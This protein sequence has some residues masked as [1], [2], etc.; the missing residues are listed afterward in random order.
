MW[1]GMGWCHKH[2]TP[3]TK[4]GGLAMNQD[5]FVFGSKIPCPQ[6]FLSSV[7][8]LQWSL[9]SPG[10][11]SQ[12]CHSPSAMFPPLSHS[13]CHGPCLPKGDRIGLPQPCYSLCKHYGYFW[14]SFS[15]PADVG[16]TGSSL[17]R[18]LLW[19]MQVQKSPR[20]IYLQTRREMKESW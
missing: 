17:S 14:L 8:S 12:G 5:L 20:I 19:F 13:P 15:I 18:L 16:A 9:V 4:F 11:I 3:R 1:L 10:M 7:V 2:L 6:K